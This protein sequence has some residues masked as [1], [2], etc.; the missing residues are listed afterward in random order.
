MNSKIIAKHLVNSL[1]ILFTIHCSLFTLSSCGGGDDD[2]RRLGEM[3]VGTWQRG[4]GEGD[5]VI[6]G[7][8]E[9]EPDNFTYDQFVFRGDG[10]YNGMV[11]KGS[12]S[13]YDDYGRIIYEGDY[14]CDNNNLKLQYIDTD[15]IK[16]TILAQVVEFSDTSIRFRYEEEQHN[17]TVT[18]IIR[19]LSNESGGYYSS[20]STTSL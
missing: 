7:N 12:F 3:I 15:G 20:S 9:L 5:V 14:Q 8:T 6:E 16:R 17:I 4:W 18:F 11:R 10:A 13:A 1:M 2:G 19:K